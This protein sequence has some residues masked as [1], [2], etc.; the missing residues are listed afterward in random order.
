MSQ[1]NETRHGYSD[2]EAAKEQRASLDLWLS[3][4][5]DHIEKTARDCVLQMG[6]LWKDLT[7]EEQQQALDAARRAYTEVEKKARN[8]EMRKR[9]S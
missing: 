9:G 7:P 4:E 8:Y 5:I 3:G 1:G 2:R 6:R